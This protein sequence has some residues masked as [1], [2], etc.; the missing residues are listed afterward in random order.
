[1]ALAQATSDRKAELIALLASSVASD[2]AALDAIYRLLSECR[3]GFRQA[4]REWPDNRDAFEQLREC[5]LEVARFEL[6]SQRLDAARALLSEVFD[7]P[8]ELIARLRECEALEQSEHARKEALERLSRDVDLT[9]SASQYAWFFGGLGT[10]IAALAATILVLRGR[11]YRLDPLGLTILAGA[12][13]AVLLVAIVLKRKTL[14]DRRASR[15]VVGLLVAGFTGVFFGRGVAV[16]DGSIAPQMNNANSIL[17]GS[18]CL[19][20]AFLLRPWFAWLA[21]LFLLAAIGGAT[22][23]R[24]AGMCFLSAVALATALAAWFWKRDQRRE[25][26]NDP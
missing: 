3:F 1:V 19:A 6:A 9:L 26:A 25:R 12:A 11:G 15:G 5:I 16:F 23:P 21:P 8:S 17:V 22:W 18:C 24:E 7:P 4:I 13:L 14:L 20:A 10:L 2:D